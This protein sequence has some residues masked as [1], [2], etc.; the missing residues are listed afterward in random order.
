MGSDRLNVIFKSTV[1]KKPNRFLSLASFLPQME[2]L[3]LET[4]CF[5]I[6]LLQLNEEFV[7]WPAYY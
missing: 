3:F 7:E 6:L 5:D 2:I 4:P 1:Q